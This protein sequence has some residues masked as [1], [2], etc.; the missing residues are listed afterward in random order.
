MCGQ[1]EWQSGEDA[2]ELL[3]LMESLSRRVGETPAFAAMARGRVRPTD[4]AP[5]WTDGGAVLMRWGFGMPAGRPVI[6]AR[7]ETAAERPLFSG[8]LRRARCALPARRFFEWGRMGR[9]RVRYACYPPGGE[10]VYLAGLYRFEPEQTLPSFVILTRPAEGA[11]ASIHSRMPV[12]ISRADLRAW[13]E[14]EEAA[15]SLLLA[16]P[17]ALKLAAE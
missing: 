7:A 11:L 13:L 8:P 6:N 2:P 9:E 17:P 16:A 3:W 10:P 5:A 12:L 1:Y 14:R 15:R 4:I